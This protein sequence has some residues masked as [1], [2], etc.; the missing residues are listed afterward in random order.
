MNET[1]TETK[2]YCF[3]TGCNKSNEMKGTIKR[4]WSQKKWIVNRVL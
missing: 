4:S 1:K 2:Y 3:G